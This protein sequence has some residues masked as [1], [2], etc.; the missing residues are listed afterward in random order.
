MYLQFNTHFLFV[1]KK[2]GE[3]VTPNRCY[4]FARFLFKRRYSRI[5]KGLNPAARQADDSC[6]I[7]FNF[8]KQ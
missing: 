3:W 7:N 6:S 5:N 4:S 8:K 1:T 2:T